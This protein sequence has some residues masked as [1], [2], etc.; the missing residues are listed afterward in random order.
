MSG[1]RDWEMSTH[2]IADVRSHIV[3]KNEM[4]QAKAW[5]KEKEA[6]GYKTKMVENYLGDKDLI[7]VIRWPDARAMAKAKK[8]ALLAEM[9]K[10]DS[11]GRTKDGKYVG[12][13]SKTSSCE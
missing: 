4:D 12:K 3:T 9:T 5:M 6:K 2:L 11:K 1:K 7:L 13:P 10:L 8:A